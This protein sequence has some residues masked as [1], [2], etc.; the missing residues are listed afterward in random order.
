MFSITWEELDFWDAFWVIFSLLGVTKEEVSNFPTVGVLNFIGF[1]NLFCLP[2][3]SILEYW[4]IWNLRCYSM[5]IQS[6]FLTSLSRGTFNSTKNEKARLFH[7]SKGKFCRNCRWLVKLDDNYRK[8]RWFFLMNELIFT[9]LY[10][11]T[12]WFLL[13]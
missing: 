4:S 5:M 12:H 11:F 2:E 3:E 10:C 1:F 6:D 7:G 13:R 9:C 8:W